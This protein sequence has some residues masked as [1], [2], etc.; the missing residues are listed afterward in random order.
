M[1]FDEGT[2]FQIL[3]PVVRGRKGEYDTL[4]QELA[5]Q[6]FSRARVDGEVVEISEFLK[7]QTPWQSTS[8]IKSTLLWIDSFDAMESTVASLIRLKLHCDSPM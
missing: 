2:R 5:S 1:K 8:N 3:A 7:K 6:G 4:L